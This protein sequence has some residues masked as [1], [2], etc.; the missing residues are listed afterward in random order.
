M[1]AVGLLATVLALAASGTVPGPAAAQTSGRDMANG[2]SGRDMVPVPV[3]SSRLLREV[4]EA[5]LAAVQ[6]KGW[7]DVGLA[8][9]GDLDGR[10]DVSRALVGAYRGA[11]DLLRSKHTLA[12]LARLRHARAGLAQLDAAVAAAPDQAEIR[13][14][15]LMSCYSLP[16]FFGRGDSVAE[17]FRSLAALLPAVRRSYPEAWW[18][19][20]V[21]FVLEHGDVDV[22]RRAALEQA[23]E[24]APATGA[25]P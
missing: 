15:R 17:D 9:L 8:R 19:G 24:A 11:F 12:P 7:I 3:S 6:E 22:G 14:V 1:K 4:R 16:F 21:R 23:L 5:W 18:Q 2:A 13:Y 25:A 20:V 10:D